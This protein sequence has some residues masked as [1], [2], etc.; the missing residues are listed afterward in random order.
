MVTELR[1]GFLLMKSLMIC[2]AIITMRASSMFIR[3][4]SVR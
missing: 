3:L 4:R 2:L 1:A